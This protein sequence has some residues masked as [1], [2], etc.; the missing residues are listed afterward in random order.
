MSTIDPTTTLGELVLDD[1]GRAETFERLGLDYCC[2]GSRTLEEACTQRGLDA[3][4]V[5]ALLEAAPPVAGGAAEHDF[6]VGRASTGE[7]CDHIVTAHHDRLRQDLPRLGD[8]VATVARVHGSAD[9]GLHDVARVFDALRVDLETHMERE[10]QHLFPACRAIDSGE[11]AADDELLAELEHEHTDVGEALIVLRDLT[12]DLRAEAARCGTHRR[13]LDG[14][15]ELERDLHRHI[16]E[17]NNV[18]FP[19]VRGRLAA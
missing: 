15:R 1:P 17:E 19:R 5:A 6:D 14:F 7:L 18:L 13:M 9:A 2:R 16:H 11:R 10:E 4:T 12:G 3:H 8:T